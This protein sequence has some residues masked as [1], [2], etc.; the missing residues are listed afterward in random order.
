MPC[1]VFCRFLLLI[2]IACGQQINA[3]VNFDVP[4]RDQPYCASYVT[5]FGKTRYCGLYGSQCPIACGSGTIDLAAAQCPGD[6][7]QCDSLIQVHGSQY[8]CS[9]YGSLCRGACNFPCS[10]PVAIAP[11][12]IIPTSSAKCPNDAPT[13]SAMIQNYGAQYYC[14]Y[15]GRACPGPCNL[16]C[17]T[18]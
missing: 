1:N 10:D 16:P 7:P 4:S 3:A 8:Y 9:L 11:V 13:C 15:Y 18:T 2:L 12:A 5:Q 6:S 14:Y 17:A